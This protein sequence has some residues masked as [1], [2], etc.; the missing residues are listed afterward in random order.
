MDALL[1]PTNGSNG[2]AM[3]HPYSWALEENNKNP[4]A[5]KRMQGYLVN[6]KVMYRYAPPDG[7]RLTEYVMAYPVDERKHKS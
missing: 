7:S 1:H 2:S 5:M 3:L 6:G 4:G